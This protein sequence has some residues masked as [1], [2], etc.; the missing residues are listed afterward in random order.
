MCNCIDIEMGTYANSIS[1]INPYSPTNKIVNVD[2]CISTEV[3]MLWNVGVR[4]TG[5]CCGHNKQ[6][7]FIGVID[8]DIPRMK[9]MSQC[10]NFGKSIHDLGWG[11]FTTQLE[12]KTL[13]SNK[14]FIKADKWFASSQ[15]CSYCGFQNKK[16][17]DIKVRK[18]TCVKCETVHHRDVNAA[19]NLRNLGFD[20]I[21]LGRP[22]SKP[23]E[24][25]T[26]T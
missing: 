6:D 20:I 1:V 18:W 3:R 8:E 22:K 4:T 17:K 14:I 21:G 24:S 12:Y 13:W 5:C 7:G 23:A 19:N 16:V 2:H 25:K 26:S 15:I 10:L 9:A 11:M